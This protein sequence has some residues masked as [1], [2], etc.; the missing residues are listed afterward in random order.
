MSIILA[1][2]ATTLAVLIQPQ[3]PSITIT[4]DDTIIDRSCTII[5]EPG[6]VIRDDN[7]NGVIHVAA[8]DITITF[9]EGSTLRGARLDTP[10]DQ[11]T[12][13]GIRLNG[14]TNITIQGARVSGYKVAIR[15]TDCDG[16]TI[17]RADLSDNYRQHLKSTPKAEV[18]SDWLWPHKNDDDEWTTNY[19]AALSVKNAS[20]ITVRN[21]LVRRGQNGI[22]LDRVTDSRI[23]DNDCSFL[24]G[25][26]L[27]LWRSSRNT[28]TRNALDFCVRGY[29]HGVYNRGQDSAGLLMF[30]QC[31]DNLIA[32][33]SITHGGDGIF[34]FGGREAIGEAP[35]PP[36]APADFYHKRGNRGNI[37]ARNDLSF[38]PAHGLE[39]TFSHDNIV[40]DNRFTGN[41]ICGIW[42]GYSH[43]FLIASNIFDSNGEL[44]YGLERGGINIEHGSGNRILNNQFSNNKCAVHL[45]WDDDGDLLKR[46]GVAAN[47]RGVSDNIIAGNIFR[48][49]ALVLHL[50]DLSPAQ[51]QVKGTVFSANKLTFIENERDITG[52]I[53]L[54]TDV[55]VPAYTIPTFEVLGDTQPVA[56][57]R[58]LSGRK[59]II[60]TQ[61]GPW[62]HAA[63]LVRPVQD[64]GSEH[65]YEFFHISPDAVS[66]SGVNLNIQHSPDADAARAWTSTI[67][68]AGGG[69]FPYTVRVAGLEEPQSV[70]GTLISTQWELAIFPWEG[71]GGP[72]PPPDLDAWRSLAE[73]DRAIHARADSLSFQFGSRGPSQMNISPEVTAANFGRD[74]FGIIATTSLPLGKGKWKIATLSDDGVRVIADGRTILEN[75]THHGATR[76]EAILELESDRTVELR[77]EYF[78]IYGAA[79]LD[80]QIEP[81]P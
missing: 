73:G 10:P 57:R 43:N 56:A 46:P 70:A 67:R 4:R 22:I 17:E 24:S 52:G 50:R 62:D 36:D 79:V 9:A 13:I 27:A 30:E 15:A 71:D 2:L 63:P 61:W 41:A 31:D 7:N 77:V 8:D 35:A 59:N 14:H 47:Y 32:E 53:E 20:N 6:T 78:E 76:D 51:D 66:I 49:D 16:L 55:P 68:A 18:S 3:P 42:G 58:H 25:W 45:W 80:V 37:I 60:M 40:V 74:Y 12:G 39:M 21:I 26:G 28:I 54:I 11:Y 33:N 23:Y 72:N 1:L 65:I 38:A 34:G 81:V 44:G 48:S 69:A 64:T 29:S 5:I 75:W 19:G